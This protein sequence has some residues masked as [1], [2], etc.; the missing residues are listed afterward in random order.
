MGFKAKL[1][2]ALGKN[3][4]DQL[5]YLKALGTVMATRAFDS[6]DYQSGK[7]LR[8]RETPSHEEFSQSIDKIGP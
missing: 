8:V 5:I 1:L 4:G 6:D 2:L 3:D 7:Q